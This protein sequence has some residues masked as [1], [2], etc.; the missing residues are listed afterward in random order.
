MNDASQPF[1]PII[2]DLA[3]DE[4]LIDIIEEF[5]DELPT[6][7]AAMCSAM[8]E[9]NFDELRRL[10]HQLKGAAGGYGFPSITDSASQV[11][12]AADIENPTQAAEKL[13]KDLE[14]LSDLCRRARAK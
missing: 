4:D 14:A 13:G 12:L 3:G 1:D 8:E 5:V 10:A 7:V 9:Q 2:S 6:R 11:E